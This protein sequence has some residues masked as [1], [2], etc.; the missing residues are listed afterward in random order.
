M[1]NLNQNKLNKA[2]A[3]MWPQNKVSVKSSFP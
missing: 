3:M 1:Q 2:L